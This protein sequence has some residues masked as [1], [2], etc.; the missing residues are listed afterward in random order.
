[1]NDK[2]IQRIFGVLFILIA[3]YT[4]DFSHWVGTALFFIFFLAGAGSILKTSEWE[5]N[6]KLATV[7]SRTA[8]VISIITLV[9]LLFQI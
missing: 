8:F 1:M 7:C 5:F 6:Q 9:R 4:M 3:I 2:I